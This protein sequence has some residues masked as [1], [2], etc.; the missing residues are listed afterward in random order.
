MPSVWGWDSI[1]GIATHYRLDNPGFKYWWGLDF[2]HP[3]RL[4]QG[5]TQPPVQRV[6]GLFT[7]GKAAGAWH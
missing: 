3:S 2:P 4:S 1:V 5:P 6:Q 7:G